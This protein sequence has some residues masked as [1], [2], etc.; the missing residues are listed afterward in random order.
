MKDHSKENR[1]KYWERCRFCDVFFGL[2]GKVHVFDDLRQPP[3][4]LYHPI[5]VYQ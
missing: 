3:R 5:A 2:G 1:A 4:I